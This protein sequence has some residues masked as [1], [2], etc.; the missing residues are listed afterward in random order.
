GKTLIR[1]V[2]CTKFVPGLLCNSDEILFS[3]RDALTDC[4]VSD[5]FCDS[6]AK[7]NQ[8]EQTMFRKKSVSIISLV[9]VVLLI[10][11]G[12]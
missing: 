8:K 1:C 6:Q 10:T 3:A 7:Q 11:G 12:L 9:L 5:N 2:E 4:E